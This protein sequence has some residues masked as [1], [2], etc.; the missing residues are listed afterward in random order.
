MGSQRGGWI[1][2][3][4]T[5]AAPPPPPRFLLLRYLSPN[6]FSTTLLSLT[7]L[8][9]FLEVEFTRRLACQF[10][11][12]SSTANNYT[13]LTTI[14]NT[15][16]EST[17]L[18]TN[19]GERRND[20][21]SEPLLIII[22]C[23]EKQKIASLLVTRE[24]VNNL[25]VDPHTRLSARRSE[26]NISEDTLSPTGRQLRMEL[27]TAA[28]SF[29]LTSTVGPLSCKINT[30]INAVK[31]SERGSLNRVPR[32]ARKSGQYMPPTPGQEKRAVA[33]RATRALVTHAREY[34]VRW[35]LRR[36]RLLLCLP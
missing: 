31:E 29:T 35:D 21:N 24:S 9:A 13:S 1:V 19:T 32:G 7:A 14:C 12:V 27:E 16:K 6:L 23:G 36:S 18:R 34:K 4:S 2:V 17:E 5:A 25:F 26:V 15:R 10:V 30:K 22:N 20:G 8:I 33:A 3:T 28:Y 11:S